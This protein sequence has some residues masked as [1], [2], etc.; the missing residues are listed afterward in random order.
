MS[1][2]GDDGVRRQNLA[3]AIMERDINETLG[4]EMAKRATIKKAIDAGLIEDED[5]T[6]YA[7]ATN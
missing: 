2:F 7:A 6:L 4:K 5:G 3:A 1:E